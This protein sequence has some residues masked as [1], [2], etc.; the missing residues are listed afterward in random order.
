[1]FDKEKIAITVN[2]IEVDRAKP[3]F[4]KRTVKV[5]LYKGGW[6]ENV[7]FIVKCYLLSVI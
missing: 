7:E 2:V 5:W 1:M 6:S 4:R 3:N